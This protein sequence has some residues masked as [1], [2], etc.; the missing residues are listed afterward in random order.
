MGGVGW[1]L[2]L[3]VLE[4]VGYGGWF[5]FGGNFHAAGG[6]VAQEIPPFGVVS[7]GGVGDA[8]DEAR[9]VEEVVDFC[10]VSV[11]E[12]M[13]CEAAEDG[14]GGKST[15]SE[16][17]FSNLATGSIMPKEDYTFLSDES[18]DENNNGVGI[19]TGCCEVRME[20]EGLR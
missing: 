4:A 2:L 13:S 10:E 19:D 5:D 12:S 7:E 6:D 14:S 18:V 8:G 11:R 9:D 3:E 1:I 17:C 20:S 16:D 15:G